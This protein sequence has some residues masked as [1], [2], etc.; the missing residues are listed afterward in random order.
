MSKVKKFVQLYTKKVK[1]NPLDSVDFE[2]VDVDLL[3]GL[4]IDQFKLAR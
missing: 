1:V 3:L 2:Y 4:Y